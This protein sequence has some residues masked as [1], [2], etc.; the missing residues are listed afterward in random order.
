MA[1]DCRCVICKHKGIQNTSNLETNKV[2]SKSGQ[3]VRVLLCRSHA[4]ELFQ[5]GQK[6]FFNKHYDILFD[7]IESEEVQFLVILH[8]HVQQ[9]K[10]FIF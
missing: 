4:V 1:N 9:Y 7:V 10:D 6:N 5:M 8:D 3:S 2:F